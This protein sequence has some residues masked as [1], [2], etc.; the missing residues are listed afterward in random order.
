MFTGHADPLHSNYEMGYWLRSD[1]CGRGLMTEAAKAIVEFAFVDLKI[2]R[3]ELH[4]G[5]ENHASIRVAQKLGFKR[6]GVLR[7]AGRGAGG[8]YDSYVF[9]LLSSDERA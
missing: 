4:A 3:V 7:E 6:E 1:L 9:G 2:H 5:T 8:F